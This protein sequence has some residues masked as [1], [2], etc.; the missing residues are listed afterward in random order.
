MT[1]DKTGADGVARA[2]PLLLDE[3]ETA[4][5]RM[6]ELDAE[7]KDM[8]GRRKRLI[9]SI[10][11]ILQT[12]D[13]AARDPWIRRYARAAAR[14]PGRPR[15]LRGP[16]RTA[17]IYLVDNEHAHIRASELTW[18]VRRAGHDVDSRYGPNTLRELA[19]SGHVSRTGHGVYRINR[20]HPELISLRIELLDAWKK[21]LFR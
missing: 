14:T 7:F 21:R 15:A 2:M 8:A 20:L 3:L 12:L 18:Y 16:L 17:M 11:N 5:A 4:N 19:A 1:P 6:K 13:A 10:D 9:A